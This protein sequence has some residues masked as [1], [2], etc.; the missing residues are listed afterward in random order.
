MEIRRN[1]IDKLVEWKSSQVHKPVLLMGASSYT[2]FKGALAENMIL[3][4]Y[5]ATLD[6]V[7]Y[8]WTSAGR[9]EIEFVVQNGVNIVPIEVKAA[10]CVGGKSLTVYNEK[11]NPA[12][13]I[14]FSANNF[15]KNDNMISCPLY[16][17]DWLFTKQNWVELL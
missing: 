17:S 10:G 14:R 5:I 8:Y 1:I 2:E 15:Q 4:S 11:F 3:Q 16:L 13:R 12:V 6:D 9:A 7:P